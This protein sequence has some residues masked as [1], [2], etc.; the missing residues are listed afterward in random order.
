MPN[1][2]DEDW[3]TVRWLVIQIRRYLYEVAFQLPNEHVETKNYEFWRDLA[4]NGLL[5]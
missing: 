5:L 2:L 4:E 1:N 3:Q